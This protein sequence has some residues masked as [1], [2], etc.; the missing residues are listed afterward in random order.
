MDR[1]VTTKV[2]SP[3]ATRSKSTHSLQKSLSFKSFAKSDE[4]TTR[5]QENLGSFH[6]IQERAKMIFKG[7]DIFVEDLCELVA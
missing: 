1:K 2:Q 5:S 6:L 7:E 4:L 3:S